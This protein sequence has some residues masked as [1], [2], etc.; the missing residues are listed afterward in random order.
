MLAEV[1]GQVLIGRKEFL[2]PRFGVAA[3]TAYEVR[4]EIFDRIRLTPDA[5]MYL[6]SYVTVQGLRSASIVAVL[7]RPETARA[8]SLLEV[9]KT[10]A[11]SCASATNS[12]SNVVSHP[13]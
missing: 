13:S 6:D 1:G 12:A 11:C 10:S 3:L 4:G 7:T 5:R 2:P 8:R 9:T